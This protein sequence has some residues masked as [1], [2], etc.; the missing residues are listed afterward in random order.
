MF[1]R[2]L[3]AGIV[4]S[5]A[6]LT[7]ATI[8]Y[9]QASAVMTS[10]SVQ[11]GYDNRACTPAIEGAIRYNS[12]ADLSG[13]DAPSDGLIAYWNMDDASGTTA[14]DIVGGY[15][16]TLMGT[17]P[18]FMPTAGQV[19]GAVNFVGH[20]SNR[21][22]VVNDIFDLAGTQNFTISI[23]M[24]LRSHTS[25]YTGMI[26]NTASVGGDRTGWS[27]TY[28][29]TDAGSP[30]EYV[31]ARFNHGN[32]VN[33]GLYSGPM[34]YYVWIHY[35]CTFDGT[36]IRTYKNGQ[37]VHSALDS[38]SIDSSLSHLAMGGNAS[39]SDAPNQPKM[40]GMLDEVRI[41]N[42]Q[43]NNDEIKRIYYCGYYGNCTL[44]PIIQYCDGQGWKNYGY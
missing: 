33:S 34:P 21:L 5:L 39:N 31:C 42:R 6:I 24:Y 4:F 11:V 9:A 44:G 37:A 29:N 25:T 15:N 19:S 20:N 36:R 22:E 7:T 27:L 18:S 14:T 43:L 13:L 32:Q 12:R 17:G 38:R 40:D 3:S 8:A 2:L 26:G 30:Y 23:W 1:L 41:Y 28:A 10:G 35:A 16:A